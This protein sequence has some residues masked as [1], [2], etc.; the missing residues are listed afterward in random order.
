MFA[1]DLGEHKSY[2]TQLVQNRWDQRRNIWLQHQNH[3]G[4]QPKMG[5]QS[6]PFPTEEMNKSLRKKHKKMMKSTTSPYEPYEAFHP[7]TEVIDTYMEIWY[8]DDSS[9]SSD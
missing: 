4:P 3:N 7:L 2:K 6:K 5:L 8:Q 9:S 1:L